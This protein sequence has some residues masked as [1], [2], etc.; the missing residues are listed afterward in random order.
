MAEEDRDER[1]HFDESAETYDRARQDYPS[2]LFDDLIELSGIP[3][4]GHILEIGCGTGKATAP[5]AR[6][7]YAITAVELGISLADVARRN[8]AEYPRVDVQVASFEDWPLPADPFDLVMAA[9]AWHWLEPVAAVAKAA[10]ALRSA[11]AL[12]IF[13]YTHVAGGTEQFFIDTQDCYER[14]DPRTP[15]GLRLTPADQIKPH[16]ADIEASGLFA[17]PKHRR[18]LWEREYTTAMYLD[19][20]STYAGNLAMQPAAREGLFAC[21]EQ[22]LQTKYN[23]RIQKAYLC[24]LIVAKRNQ[25][26]L[27][28]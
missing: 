6:R 7:G 22:L 21:I 15:A 19:V 13:G 10:R 18:Y 11:G 25:R 27:S 20:L 26:A 23:G 16:T 4:G 1:R 9:T 14:W 5:M 3:V 24:D 17:P 8:L 12:A 28:S 2:E